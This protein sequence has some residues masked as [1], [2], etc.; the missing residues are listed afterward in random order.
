MFS[1]QDIS[2]SKVETIPSSDNRIHLA[3]EQCARLAFLLEVKT[4]VAWRFHNGAFVAMHVNAEETFPE[5][6]LRKR[7]TNGGG[8]QEGNSKDPLVLLKRRTWVLFF[9]IAGASVR[10]TKGKKKPRRPKSML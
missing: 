7:E 8:L 10:V 6:L 5:R 2:V 3:S 4:S 9:T 1:Y